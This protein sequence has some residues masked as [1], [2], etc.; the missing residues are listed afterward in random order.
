[1]D[2]EYCGRRNKSQLISDV[3]A[4]RILESLQNLAAGILDSNLTDVQVV[5][6]RN[7]G[8]EKYKNAKQGEESSCAGTP[9]NLTR[10]R[11]APP[12][13]EADPNE[14]YPNEI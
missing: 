14:Q 8:E 3:G 6:R 1:M 9:V 12:K 11:R 2:N 4:G 7:D 10:I 13:E 5:C